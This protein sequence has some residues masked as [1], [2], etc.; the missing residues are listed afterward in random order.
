MKIKPMIGQYQ[1]PGIQRIGTSEDRRLVEISVPGLE[2]SLTQDLGSRSVAIHI[3]GTLAGDDARDGFLDK[4]RAMLK[5]GKPVAFVADIANA[6]SIDKVMV[7]E[8]RVNEVAGSSDSFRYEMVLTQFVE[9]P[10]EA[11]GFGDLSDVNAAVAD[12]AGKQFGAA[13]VPDVINSIPNFGDPTPPL[14]GAIDGVK[15]AV[16]TLAP[17]QAALAGLFGA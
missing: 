1:V 8:L 13:Q 14:K 5:D 17:V 4:V 2:G 16:N 7:A 10:P 3:Q 9:P 12:E 6:T 11:T 15:S